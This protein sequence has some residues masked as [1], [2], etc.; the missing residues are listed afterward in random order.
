[1]RKTVKFFVFL[2]V[3]FSVVWTISADENQNVTVVSEDIEEFPSTAT[4]GTKTV[5][6][7][8]AL[9]W[10]LDAC[11]YYRNYRNTER[12]TP[13]PKEELVSAFPD[14][15]E[16][17]AIARRG[18]E[19][20]N[21]FAFDTYKKI[22]A[23]GEN[24]LYFSPYGVY[25]ALWEFSAFWETETQNNFFKNETGLLMRKL[26]KMIY[27]NIVD[28]LTKREEKSLF[29]DQFS[30]HPAFEQYYRYFTGL[31][32]FSRHDPSFDMQSSFDRSIDL[33]Q[34]KYIDSVLDTATQYRES[35]FNVSNS[36]STV[37]KYNWNSSNTYKVSLSLMNSTSLD[38]RYLAER[39]V[40]LLNSHPDSVEWHDGVVAYTKTEEFELMRIQ[41]GT[42]KH[43]LL[44]IYPNNA[45][46]FKKI[47]GK[48][49]I[50]TLKK[51]LIDAELKKCAFRSFA[52]L[53]GNQRDEMALELNL[54]GIIEGTPLVNFNHKASFTAVRYFFGGRGAGLDPSKGIKLEMLPEIYEVVIPFD[55]PF[56]FFV[57]DDPTGV[58]LIMGRSTGHTPAKEYGDNHKSNLQN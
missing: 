6:N 16:D 56:L 51:L 39:P 9:D 19:L 18:A 37:S 46:E 25:T 27:G 13:S 24:K 49:D 30:L 38:I 34:F 10:P 55:H 52:G 17:L 58:I 45:N 7:G 40:N 42:L 48:M 54:T 35:S 50:K 57:I 41:F 2:L 53:F 31:A 20:V 36:V 14:Y 26:K 33:S 12:T 43:S 29:L 15:Y 47:E 1:M 4:D 3:L 21:E 44:L 32:Q 5:I 8:F 23:D 28:K 11:T 22:A